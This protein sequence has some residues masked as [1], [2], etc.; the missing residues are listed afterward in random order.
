[1]SWREVNSFFR[2]II[3]Y[4]NFV[5]MIHII[6]SYIMRQIVVMALERSAQVVIKYSIFLK[7]NHNNNILY[8]FV[9]VCPFGNDMVQH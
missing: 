6:N 3:I 1:M 2:K 7:N 4:I 5:R 8:S 9:C